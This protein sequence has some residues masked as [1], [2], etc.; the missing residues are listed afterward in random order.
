MKSSIGTARSFHAAGTP[1]DLCHAHSR[2]ALATSAAAIALRRGLGADLTDAQLLECIAEA[3][4][5][6]SA[7][8]PSPETRLAVRAALRAPLTRADDPQE[9]ADAVFDTLPDTPLR[10]EGANGQ[11]FFL[12]PIAAP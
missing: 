11:V 8:A 3:R 1:G 6:A 10:V 2:A 9:L 7:P 4:D 12:V 5:D